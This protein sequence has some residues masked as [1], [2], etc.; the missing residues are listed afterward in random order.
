MEEQE[1]KIEK[2]RQVIQITFLFL[3][4]IALAVMVGITI[5]IVKY[6]KMLQNPVGYNLERFG[7]NYCTCYDQENRIIPIKSINY[8]NISDS[9]IPKPEYSNYSVPLLNFSSIGT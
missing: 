6:G 8:N 9:V 7:I 5:T 3:I 2:R 1:I 4:I